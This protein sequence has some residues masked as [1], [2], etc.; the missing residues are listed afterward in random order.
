MRSMFSY[1]LSNLTELRLVETRHAD[2][3][4]RLVRKNLERLAVWCPWVDRVSTIEATELFL[5][6]RIDRFAAGNGFTTGI[7]HEGKLSGVIALE[8][9][10]RT[11]ASTE[12]GYWL[13]SDVE[14][15]GIVQG[16][17]KAL[18]QHSFAELK[19]RR[20]QI[21]CA[22]EN[23]RSRAIPERLGFRQEGVIRRCEQLRDR[24]VDLVVYGMLSEEWKLSGEPT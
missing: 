11:N 4:F 10:E 19:L 13:D 2:E 22:V 17:C 12:I 6:E 24:V 21:R 8:Y 23:R 16:A 1:R 15:K 18:I 5:R 9:I 14:G 20:V 3:F 7:F